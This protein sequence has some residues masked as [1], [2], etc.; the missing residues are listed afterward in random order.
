[1]VLSF[2][3]ISVIHS[4]GA[5]LRNVPQRIIQPDGSVLRCFASGDEFF[6]WLHDKEGYTIIQDPVTG[7]YVYATKI[8]QKLYPT[9]HIAGI[10]NPRNIA[11]QQGVYLDQKKIAEKRNV[12]LE[13]LRMNDS[14]RAPTNGTLN[15]I[16]IFIRFSDQG[17]FSQQLS[18]YDGQFNTDTNSMKN[19]YFEA[20]YE[21]LTIESHFYP[22]PITG[23]VVSYQDTHPRNYYQPYNAVTNPNGYQNDNESRLREHTLLKNAVNGVAGQIPVDL[24]LDLDDDG[25]VDNVC[26]F[27]QGAA[28]GWSDLLWPH[29][30]VLWSFDP[31]YGDGSGNA[32]I[33][34]TTVWT[35]NFNLSDFFASGTGVLCHE[36]FHSL[37]APDL[38]HY[39]NNGI[40]PVGSWDLMENTQNPPQHMGSYMKYRY[41]GWIDN[42]PEIVNDG[43][44]TINPLTYATNNCY[45]IASPNST[46]EYFVVEYRKKEGTFESSLPGSGLIV[47]RI[48]T[49]EDGEG[50]ANG[51]PD[52]VYIYRPG[53]T[54]SQNGSINSAN[55]SSD[56]GRT[57]INDTTDPSS[58][59]SDGSDGG[60]DIANIGTAVNNIQ[61]TLGG[62]SPS[63]S[64]NNSSFSQTLGSDETA[65]QLL[66]TTNNGEPG[67]ILTYSISFE[68]TPPLTSLNK[69]MSIGGSTFE[70]VPNAYQPGT[71][72]NIGLT[73]TN[74]SNDEEWLDEASL[75]FPS[76][77]T[78]NSS[79]HFV[80][81][82]YGRLETNNQT[83][84]G[85]TVTWTDQNGGFG[86]VAGGESAVGTVNIT[87]DN[88]FSGNMNLNW[89][90]S[91]DV[92]GGL[93]H[94]LS[95]GLTLAHNWL[96]P[97][98]TSGICAYEETDNISLNFNSTGLTYGTYNGS[99]AI[100]HNG[101]DQVN[102]PVNLTV[103]DVSTPMHISMQSV[104]GTNLQITFT[105]VEDVSS[106]NIYR[107]TAATF[108]PD[109][110]N[111]TNRVANGIS[112]E[113]PDTGGV[114][115]TDSDNVVGNPSIN[116]FYAV[117]ALGEEESNP[118]ERFGEFDFEL[119]TTSTTDFNEI[120]I[121]LI[122]S[123]IT[124]AQNL[125]EAISG[126][127]SAAR[128]DANIQGYEQYIQGIPPTN[129]AVEMGYPYYVNVTANTVFTL[130][131]ELTTPS[132]DLI[133]TPTTDFNEIMLTL[134]KTEITKSSHLMAD[135]PNCNSVARWDATIQGYQQYIQGIP[136][137]DFD[138]RVGYPY[139]VNVTA[140]VTWPGGGTSKRM[141]D[142]PQITRH[143]TGK[144]TPHCVWGKIISNEETEASRTHFGAFI[145]SR[146]EERLT[147]D[148]P[149][150][151]LID[152]YWIVQCGSFR[153]PWTAG[154]TLRVEF[155]ETDKQ[156]FKKIEVEL[157]Y[158]PDD[159]AG[160]IVIRKSKTAPI[161]FELKQNVPNP[162]NPETTI[163]YQLSEACR[164]Q[165]T[166]YNIS[167]QEVRYL[168]DT[169]MDP[170]FHQITWD[171]TDN[172]GFRQTSGIYLL[173]FKAGSIVK[174][175][176]MM[177]I[178]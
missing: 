127:N 64:V 54:P 101:G 143:D 175:Q 37:G 141:G 27:I 12:Y 98:P 153:S 103:S 66:T 40:S 36:M 33:N 99:I 81:G 132:F 94:D 74:N 144:Q 162:F 112:D 22:E 100:S 123:G 176:K 57:E 156:D 29:M 44:Y 18:F 115:W 35:Y 164:V 73:I 135:I 1:M 72:F 129:F 76:G 128:W 111:G 137:T 133:T 63:I 62:V 38:Y 6:H 161:C 69:F 48:N 13:K 136:P 120:A 145:T 92:Y 152:G 119:I 117:T 130:L 148:S 2:F 55:F 157:T 32:T 23:Q 87:V 60:L 138:V 5:Y 80:G 154:D 160:Q 42:I 84:D 147:E 131:G 25:L 134:E 41:G 89:I 15:N 170:G 47:Y 70:C 97:N 77:V 56:V 68:T 113:D 52:E 24:D 82:S 102:I 109:L 124:T 61:F 11:I 7:Y 95:G 31:Y 17:E 96:I 108:S 150:C 121:P 107:S 16:V 8:D 4:Y 9:K 83:G 85:V 171:G 53:G 166:I 167:G 19:Y 110:T 163:F 78:V 39:T 26:F 93:P 104:N 142:V 30:W 126:C 59:L 178:H 158:R 90:L 114:Q 75:D 21:A 159:E 139:Y 14:Y 51:P 20:S 172:D 116:Y 146:P 88:S 125:M 173:V 86:N 177:M 49:N 79:T 46:S 155:N 105:Q 50:N 118:S 91:G 151:S 122:M 174:T 67:S 58:F 106:Y 45:K 165:M 149:G 71:T 3:L 168:I 28:D 169:I 140:D 10:S 34:G 65:S 43:V